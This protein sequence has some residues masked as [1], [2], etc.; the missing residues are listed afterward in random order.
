MHPSFLLALTGGN[1]VY[2]KTCI[3]APT[4]LTTSFYRG[5]ETQASAGIFQ[6]H[7]SRVAD[8]QLQPRFAGV[9]GLFPDYSQLTG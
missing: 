1:R 8:L 3:Y 7:S 2:L 6:I 5:E 9:R 4:L